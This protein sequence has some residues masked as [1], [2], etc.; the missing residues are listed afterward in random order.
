M[1]NFNINPEIIGIGPVS[2]RYYG[3]IYALGF[4][5]SFLYLDYLRKKNRLELSRDSIYDLI[6][7]LV[8]GVVLGARIFEVLVW[9]PG[10][11]FSNPGQIIAIWNG[12]LSFHGGLIGAALACYLF[13]KKHKL[14]FLKLADAIIIPGTLALALGRI[15]NF[16]NGELYGTVTDVSWCVNFPDALGC[17]HPYQIYASLG[18]LASFLILLMLNKKE[19]KQGFIF[20]MGILLFGAFR[21]ILDFWRE[22][23]RWL[24]LSLGQYLSIPLILMA[25]YVLLKHYKS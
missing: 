13:S 25:G 2:I 1:F 24:G 23:P 11:Y 8:I 14:S 16:L 15:G 5:I 20:W 4:I 10:Y 3:V 21:L 22:D 9:S 6:F 7:Y 12:G 17:R 19:R 18:H